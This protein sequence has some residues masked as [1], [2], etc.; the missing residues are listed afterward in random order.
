MDR[1]TQWL[2]ERSGLAPEG[3][4]PDEFG[5][6]L[7]LLRVA[8]GLE[9]EG[10]DADTSSGSAAVRHRKRRRLPDRPE[11]PA[12]PEPQ[13][14]PQAAPPAP[15]T[16]TPAPAE[17]INPSETRR[18]Q[19]GDEPPEAS[20]LMPILPARLPVFPRGL[21]DIGPIFGRGAAPDLDTDAKA[22][23]RPD[24]DAGGRPARGDDM[25][26]T[27][28]TPATGTSWFDLQ[29]FGSQTA[30]TLPQP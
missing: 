27:P 29:R 15:P 12:R 7:D 8:A 2:L 6:F 21:R 25:G 20:A 5:A 28:P 1:A 23:P 17:P 11:R 9:A 4:L 16:P 30:P 10:I 3:S 22:R 14:Q 26:P 19:G 24:V 18:S 13:A